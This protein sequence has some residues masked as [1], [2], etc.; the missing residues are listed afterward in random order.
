VG[1]TASAARSAQVGIVAPKG[2]VGPALAVLPT[3]VK[4]MVTDQQMTKRLTDTG[5]EAVY[6]LSPG[7]RHANE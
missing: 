2:T 3:A 7:L 4:T 1:S 6:P 5:V